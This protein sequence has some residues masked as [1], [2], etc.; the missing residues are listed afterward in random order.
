MPPAD[1]AHP[2]IGAATS[3]LD[4]YTPGARF[5]ATPGRTLL[6]QGDARQVPHDE[7]PLDQRVRAT[8]A[9]AG[10]AGQESPVVI[11]AIPFDHEAPAALSVPTALRTAPPLASDPLIALPVGVPD[12]ANWR[13]RPVPEPEVY[14]AGVASAVERMWRGEFSKVVLART[15]E[16]TSPAP[17]DLPA[18]L[19]RLA[20]RDPVG[21]TFALPT[22][23]GR[24]LI[25]ASPELLV[26]R[27]GN[28][29]TANPL[30]GSTPRST[31]LAEDVRRAATLLQSAKDLHEHAVVVDAVHQALA[32]HCSRL[33][34]PARPTLIRTATMWHLSTTVTGT[35]AAPDTSALALACA[36][37]P[38]PAVCGTPTTTA[39]RVIAE[40][41][42]FD[43]GFFTGVVGWGNAQGDGEWV[44]TI[45]CAEAEERTLRL[46]AG[47]GVVSASEPEAETAE[48]AAK[49]RTFLN[50]VGAE[51]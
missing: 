51:L 1:P 50:A 33:T 30:A 31:D 11:G 29:V 7:R 39:R 27:K 37:H 22:G 43:R 21:Y 10:A 23:P 6:A 8:L 36:L 48:T 20:R 16:L 44:V 17:L 28:Q 2:V 4:A 32:P 18:M 49:F 5:L 38:T 9:E 40:T 26:S 3:L 24:T 42:P 45:R 14:G 35:L 41:E 12:S 19:Q 47:A 46:Y 34:V 25:G 15:L 13:I